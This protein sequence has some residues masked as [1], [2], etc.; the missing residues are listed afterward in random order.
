MKRTLA[1]TGLVILLATMSE[2]CCAQWVK[3]DALYGGTIFPTAIAGS[4]TNLLLPGTKA[5]T[6]RLTME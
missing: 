5:F 3:C 1:I 6:A 2:V 4:E